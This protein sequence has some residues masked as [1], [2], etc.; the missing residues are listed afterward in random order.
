MSDI[1]GQ[2]EVSTEMT[3]GEPTCIESDVRRSRSMPSMKETGRAIQESDSSFMN[4]SIDH[5]TSPCD[6]SIRK[7]VDGVS[8]KIDMVSTVRGWQE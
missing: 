5:W 8:S 7:C 2:I 1:C 3:K 4:H 6:A